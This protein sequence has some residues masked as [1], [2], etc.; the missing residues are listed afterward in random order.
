MAKKIRYVQDNEWKNFKNFVKSEFICG[1]NKKYCNGF[2]YLPTYSLVNTLQLIRNIWG[3]MT[4]TS[5]IRCQ[6]FNDSLVGSVQN[7]DH[8]KG[9]SADI[10]I[11][12]AK[13][14]SFMN[15]LE[16]NKKAFN[17]DYYYTNDSNMYNAVHISVFP[18]YFD[19]EQ[20]QINDL[21]KQVESLNKEVISKN[22]K[23]TL[24]KKE[25]EEKLIDIQENEA[26][27]IEISNLNNEIGGYKDEI[28]K[29]NNK[30]PA[31]QEIEQEVLENDKTSIIERLIEFIIKIFKK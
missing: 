11:P 6:K 19:L 24:L 28:D 14:K 18:T 25:L 9:L 20:D 15:I 27:K 5:G 13:K 23:I 26:N 12:Y 21:K 17:I 31:E 2:P 30:V 1:C 7:S 29:L 22:D 8:L 4:I 10:L 3:Q 16:K